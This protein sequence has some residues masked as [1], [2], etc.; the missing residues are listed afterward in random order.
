MKPKTALGA[1]LLVMVGAAGG[2]LFE[3]N[4]L[5]D[6]RWHLQMA[7]RLKAT[8]P[9]TKLSAIEKKAVT[10]WAALNGI[11]VMAALHGRQTTI[12]DLG[13]RTCVA[14]LLER[15]AIGGSP[16]Y[17][18]DKAGTLVERYDRVE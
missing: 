4:R 5:A 16:V 12:L 7:F 6:C 17:C 10:E 15:G 14:L 18:F 8:P 13:N 1:A 11:P 3:H 2:W 9:F